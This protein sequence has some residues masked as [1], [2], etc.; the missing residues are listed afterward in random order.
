LVGR[1]KT[2][3]GG[4]QVGALVYKVTLVL[5]IKG[6]KPCMKNKDKIPSIKSTRQKERRSKHNLKK[7]RKQIIN[8]KIRKKP[9][10]NRAHGYKMTINDNKKDLRQESCHL[11][12]IR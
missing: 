10:A 12:Q 7:K 3:L 2:T 11:S 6:E 1:F 9:Y 8:K 5:G 4:Y